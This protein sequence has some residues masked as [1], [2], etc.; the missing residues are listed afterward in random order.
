MADLPEVT[1]DPGTGS[2]AVYFCGDCICFILSLSYDM[3]GKAWVR[4]N[5]G[6]A[7]IARR[8][9]MDRVE[10]NDIA[11]EKGWYDIP[12]TPSGPARFAITLPLHEVGHFQ[13][14]CFFIPEE[15]NT[16][17]WP[18]GDNTIINVEPAGTCCSNII[19]NAFVR[20][21]GD[22][23]TDNP[24]D[25]QTAD[26]VQRLD[27]KGYTVIPASG[28]FRDLKKEIRFIF[29]DLGCRI[30]HLLPVHPTPTT[31]ARMGRFGSPYAALNF[32]DV[33][34]ALAE[35]DPAA[36]PLEQFMELADMVHYY[37]GYLFMD[38]A[39]NHTGWAA[40][41]HESHPEWLV[42]ETD[43][44]IV[45]PE[46]WGVVWADLTRLDYSQKA[47]WQ[48]MADMF[49]LWCQRG[50]DG[51]RC[52]AGYMIP[53]Q[54]WEY[55][56]AKVRFEHP[57]ALFFLE[58][59]GGPIQTTCDILNQANFNWAYSELFQNYTAEQIVPY[60]E[61]VFEQST[62]YGQFIHFAETHDNNRL[63]AVSKAYAKM[64]TALCA[65]FSVCGGFGF[66]NGVEWYAT[67]KIDVHES[68]S[69]NWGARDN[70]VD[71]IK[72]LNLILK[73]H[74]AFF[75][76]TALRFI[77]SGAK[78]TIILHRENKRF[79]KQVMVLVNLDCEHPALATW[80]SHKTPGL[81]ALTV[82]LI[83]GA[84]VRI[85]QEN[86]RC[87]I[88]LMPGEV[89]S[90][91]PDPE[92]LEALEPEHLSLQ[93]GMPQRVYIQK[94]KAQMLSIYTWFF[95]FK[96]MGA[97]DPDPHIL[98]FADDPV[99]YI[100]E[101]NIQTRGSK[102]SRVV[103]FDCSRDLDRE[104]MVPPDYF[105]MVVSDNSFRA[106]IKDPSDSG[107][108]S[109]GYMEGLLLKNQS[110]YFTI[111]N[112]ADNHLVD[113]RQVLLDLRIFDEKDRTKACRVPVLILAHAE[114]IRM[115]GAFGRN[116]ILT[117]P[118][119]KLLA[120]SARGGYMRAPA[121]WGKLESRYDALLSA[122]LNPELPENRWI[123]LS[124]YRIWSV[125]QDHSVELSLD[126]LDTFYFSYDGCGKWVFNI[127]TSEGK[128]YTLY[129][130]LIFNPD[131]NHVR[132]IISRPEHDLDDPLGL[133]AAK[134]VTIIIRPDIEDRSFHDTVKAWQGSESAWPGTVEPESRGFCFKP[135][136]GRKLTVRASEGGYIAE[137]EW[138]YM[139]HRELEAQ[140]GLDAA[141][142]LFSPGY[143]KTPVKGTG[144]V[145]LDAWV[146]DPEPTNFDMDPDQVLFREWSLDR[147]L[148]RSL[149]AFLV[150]R[151]GDLSVIAG[152]PW[153][154]DWGR[155]SLI[156]C[157][158]LIELERFQDARAVLRLF[159]RFEENGTLPNMICGEDAA[160]RE[161]SDAPLWFI[162]CVRDLVERE[163]DET[164]LE[165][166][167]GGRS[168]RE[169]VLSIGKAL[170]NGTPTGVIA[171]S[172][173]GLLY[174]PSHY[175]WMDTNYPAATPREGY[176]VEI[177][178]LWFYAVEFFSR[179]DQPEAKDGWNTL[180]KKVRKS[181]LDYYY[182][183]SKGYFSDCRH[184]P[185]PTGAAKALQDDA[186]RPNQLFL[187]T[188]GVI[189]DPEIT[190]PCVETCMELL[191]PGGIRS[192]SNR[193]VS[194][195]LAVA[196]DGELIN[197]PVRPYQGRYEGDEDRS[198]KKAYHNGTAWTWPFPVFCEAWA[199][200]FGPESHTTVRA[201]L[202]TAVGLM[203]Q[204]AAGYLPE[205]MD[206]DTPHRPRGC[207][208][209]AWGSSEFI[210]V[211]RLLTRLQ[212]AS[213]YGHDIKTS[214]NG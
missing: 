70:Q 97:F 55:I 163:A 143:F 25:P 3:P 74:P 14:K 6:Q 67:Q 211:F 128:H 69:L 102:E 83:T 138:A 157:R 84:Q 182:M 177:Q 119:L 38:I 199:R 131:H 113:H 188:L 31:Y 134:P 139:V 156:F 9:I 183:A 154:L 80:S 22:S 186:L 125:F 96:D 192:L 78:E 207:D 95:G 196:H 106:Q 91:T 112:P 27:Q 60:L 33:D 206:G 34:P 173:T 59:L 136:P 193:E 39:I 202:S 174:S 115:N 145:V 175:T 90:L 194:L 203:R 205:I 185:S 110:R 160:N 126:C 94:L 153:F 66:A 159:G 101:L 56:I 57:Q 152:Y 65:L 146:N 181:I 41:L 45:R 180:L 92:D 19:Y 127:P 62:R 118:S 187:F 30:L 11:L 148:G 167:L 35:F 149:D 58:G 76:G 54:A 144:Q 63:A 155:D 2:A 105:L 140:R 161:T 172:D 137:P 73:V 93:K 184:S 8:E 68:P 201:W 141:S 151:A 7:A 147:A 20:Q 71:H 10:R 204:G 53:V 132:M 23:K 158:S 99:E 43:G 179:I 79:G 116:E 72:R 103:V 98:K 123:F 15:R 85:G 130:F 48:Y 64:R 51:F 52:D 108:L 200:V 42:R 214:N 109:F 129:L 162:A 29:S 100:R 176:P 107:R 189:K 21:F 142:D 32:T 26:M 104:V 191:V 28:K 50:V 114:R 121:W 208:A 197:D 4:T 190:I 82:D 47:L 81:D 44:E 210:R 168:V 18:A 49:I 17:V 124:R 133:E 213:S 88:N 24:D 165:L 198:R 178:A 37:N 61:E 12:M 169:V 150:K 13:A 212:T 5:L 164:F 86:Q 77:P 89:L 170:V 120:T 195:P 1:Q 209:Q 36:T 46:A 111:F 135:G 40:T 16:P 87:F 117:Y 122:N 75:S 166:D 171:D